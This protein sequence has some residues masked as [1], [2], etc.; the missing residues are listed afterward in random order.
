[1][2]YAVR[3]ALF[4]S[5][6]K[7]QFREDQATPDGLLSLY[8]TLRRA[9]LLAMTFIDSSP[10]VGRWGLRWAHSIGGEKRFLL[11][12]LPPDRQI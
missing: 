10:L 6:Q 3:G 8:T 4:E 11:F 9:T 1:M 12:E 5:P 7:K 2:G